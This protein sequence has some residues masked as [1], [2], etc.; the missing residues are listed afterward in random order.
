M[1][2][3]KYLLVCFLLMGC[4]KKNEVSVTPSSPIPTPSTLPTPTPTPTAE[5][6]SPTAMQPYDAA[7]ASPV[8]LDLIFMSSTAIYSEVY[9]M[10]TTPQ[11]YVGKTVRVIGNFSSGQDPEGNMVFACVIPD[12]TKCCAQ[13]MQF[14]WEGDHTYPDDYPSNGEII[15]VEG[16]F[17]Y[18]EGYINNIMLE[19]ASAWV[20]RPETT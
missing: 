9:N 15:I 13:G 17:N 20:L 12:A 16:T 6:T 1:K 19:N 11:D 5:L 4:V 3:I 2:Y 7:Y 8:D 14:F 10:M 18:E